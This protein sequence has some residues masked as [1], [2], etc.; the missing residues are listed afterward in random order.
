MV[1]AEKVMQEYRPDLVIVL[2]DV[3]ST[4]ACGF[5]VRYLGIKL[6]HLESGL[7]SF[8]IGMPEEINRKLVDAIS[9]Y[10]FVTE[11]SGVENLVLVE[12]LGYFEFQKL[13]SSSKV[14]VTDPCG[15]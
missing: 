13:V 4:F 10:Y 11:P 15:I 12:S 8:D 3:N 6:A 9:D 2:G 5:V 14:V 7:R 1:G